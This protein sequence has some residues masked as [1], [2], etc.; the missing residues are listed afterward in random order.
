MSKSFSIL[1][2]SFKDFDKFFVGFDDQISRFQ[3]LHGDVTKNA[4]NYPPYNI[5]KLDDVHYSVEMAVAGFTEEEIEVGFYNNELVVCGE[6]KREESDNVQYI[7][8]GISAR[9]FRRAFAINENLEVLSA[10]LDNGILR[11]RLK[12]LIPEEKLPKKIKVTN[13]ATKQLLTE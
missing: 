13:V 5:I 10:D 1:S 12:K 8:R 3:K 2:D 9:K 6:I 11:I 4:N 7:H